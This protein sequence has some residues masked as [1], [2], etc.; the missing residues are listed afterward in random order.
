MCEETCNDTQKTIQEQ[1]HPEGTAAHE[2]IPA[3][4][5]TTVKGTAAWE[6]IHTGAV[7]KHKKQGLPRKETTMH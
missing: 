6:G 1:I 4:A 5:D 3:G 7:K 2:G